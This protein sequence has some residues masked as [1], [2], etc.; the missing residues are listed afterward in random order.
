MW[1][2]GNWLRRWRQ[3]IAWCL[4]HRNYPADRV[5]A[6]RAGEGYLPAGVINVLF[7]KGK[8]VGDP[9]TGIL[10]CGWCR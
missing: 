3:E 8:T 4:N 9:L 6:G 5:E 10:K 2:R 7:G 1:Q